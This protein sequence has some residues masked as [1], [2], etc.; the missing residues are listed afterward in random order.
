[1]I[2]VY[3]L[4]SSEDGTI[5]YIGQT[6]MPPHVRLKSHV[7]E[8]FGKKP[9]QTHKGHWIRSVVENGH[10][11]QIIVLKTNA[12]YNEDE[13]LFIKFYKEQGFSLVNAT[14]G[15]D[16]AFE[17]SSEARKKMSMRR[18]GKKLSQ[19]TCDKLSQV[20]KGRKISEATKQK[21]AA[22][23]R[24][25]KRPLEV[26]EKISKTLHGRKTSDLH[27]INTSKGLLGKTR[28]PFTEEHKKNLSQSHRQRWLN[29]KAASPSAQ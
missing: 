21:I 2:I 18:K 15:G 7:G 12:V 13:K 3:G 28:K 16:H 25:R 8:A 29:K 20:R 5:R 22:S 26:C 11:V 17:L 4:S 10:Q 24:G 1:M 6:K 14:D 19:E 27:R 9:V 23:L